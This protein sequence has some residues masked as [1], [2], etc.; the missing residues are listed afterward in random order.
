MAIMAPIRIKIEENIKFLDLAKQISLNTLTLF[1][2]Q[3]YP[4]SKTLEYVHKETDITG[5]LYNVVFNY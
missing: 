5:N 3:K 2:H 1:R 4:Y